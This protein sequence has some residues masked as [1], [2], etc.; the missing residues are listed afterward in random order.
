[1][2]PEFIKKGLSRLCTLKRVQIEEFKFNFELPRSIHVTL[3]TESPSVK[4]PKVWNSLPYHIK[5][6]ENLEVIK[7]VVMFWDGKTCN[8]NFCSVYEGSSS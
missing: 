6:V 2:N 8:G 4:G 3:R 5:V 1:M 7:R